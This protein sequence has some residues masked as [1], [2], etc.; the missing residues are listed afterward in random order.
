MILLLCTVT[1]PRT[2]RT[3][4]VQPHP[5]QYIAVTFID[6]PVHAEIRNVPIIAPTTT[7]TQPPP[8]PPPPPQPPTRCGAA[9]QDVEARGDHLAAGFEFRCPDASYPHW[10][11]TTVPPCGPCYVMINTDRIGPDD[12][13]LRYVVAH[14]FCHSNGIR[15]ERAADNCAAHYGYPNRYFSR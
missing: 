1:G 11:A 14:E 7:T 4:F 2:K 12:T 9:R 8:P 13:K 15:D 3:R 10:G 5:T 6:N